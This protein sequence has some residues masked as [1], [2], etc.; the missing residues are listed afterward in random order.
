MSTLVYAALN[1]IRDK[2]TPEMPSGI[3][4]YVDTMAALVPA[5]VLTLHALTLSVTTATM[6]DASGKVVTKITDG[7]TLEYAFWALIAL[8][9]VLYLVPRFKTWKR[10]DYVRAIIPPCAFVVWTML[11][12]STA[13]DAIASGLG[14]APRTVIALFAAAII[15]LLGAMLAV[16]AEKEQPS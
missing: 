2:A 6:T 4:T 13:F 8:S 15:G 1:N 12:R 16:K 9:V 3:K 5:E 14:N 7:V 10:L 11:Q